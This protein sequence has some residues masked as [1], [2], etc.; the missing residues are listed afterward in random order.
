MF[1]YHGVHIYGLVVLFGIM[2][3]CSGCSI[4]IA[5]IVGAAVTPLVQPQVDRV[6]K[7]TGL[8]WVDPSGVAGLQ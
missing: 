4:V 5:G 1:G 3:T 2:I 6:L 8:D 7:A